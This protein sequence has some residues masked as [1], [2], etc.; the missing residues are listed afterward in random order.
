MT[1]YAASSDPDAEVS[2]PNSTLLTGDVPAG[3]GALRKQAGGNL[4]I[5]GSGQLVRSLLSRGLVDGLFLMIHR[6]CWTLAT[7]CSGPP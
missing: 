7:A 6:P 5:M 2:W 1:K 3:A 4:V